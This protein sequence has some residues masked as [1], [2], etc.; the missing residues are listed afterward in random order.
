MTEKARDSTIKKI[1]ELSQMKDEK[2]SQR[3]GRLRTSKD[4][5]RLWA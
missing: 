3:I 2:D 5:R 4:G 1:I